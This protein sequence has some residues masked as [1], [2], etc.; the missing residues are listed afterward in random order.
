VP[1]SQNESSSTHGPDAE[2]DARDAD[3]YF[4]L[5]QLSM[6]TQYLRRLVALPHWKTARFS[7]LDVIEARRHIRTC[8]QS[9]NRIESE[10]DKRG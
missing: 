2:A 1:N 7:A 4:A 8:L 9:L 6:T 3:A 10:L 5:A